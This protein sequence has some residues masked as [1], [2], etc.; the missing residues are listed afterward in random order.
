MILNP[1]YLWVRKGQKS[2]EIHKEV[3]SGSSVLASSDGNN[4]LRLLTRWPALLVYRK[5]RLFC[6]HGRRDVGGWD[7]VYGRWVGFSKLMPLLPVSSAAD[8]GCHPKTSTFSPASPSRF[9]IPIPIDPRLPRFPWG[10]SLR[11]DPA[12]CCCHTKWSSSP[13]LP[14]MMP[15]HLS[16][17][18]G[19]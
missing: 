9:L 16:C 18:A 4:D 19:P 5:A 15:A 2:N 11:N 12:G 17:S 14:C 1:Q 10:W 6:A 7:R 13:S 3:M 8:A